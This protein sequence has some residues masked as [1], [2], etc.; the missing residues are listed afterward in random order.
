MKTNPKH[1]FALM[2]FCL[3][4]SVGISQTMVNAT[5]IMRNISNKTMWDGHVMNVFG[6][7]P[8]IGTVP[9]PGPTIY[10]NEGDTLNIFTL[11]ISQGSGHTIHP[12]G[13]DVPQNMD[14]VHETSFE[15]THMMDTNLIWVATHAG[16][17]LYHC[18]MASV[19][20]VQMGMYGSIVVR[21]AGGA[22]TAYTGGPA[23][24]QEKLWLMSEM[25]SYWH[26]SLPGSAHWMNYFQVPP[27]HPDYFLVNG[28]S[29]FQL[30]DTS[31]AAIRAQV[32]EKVYVRLSNIGYNMDEVEFPADMNA[33]ILSADGRP[34]PPLQRNKINVC[35]GER[36]GVML[37]PS[38]ELSYF[39][40]IRYLDM[41][42]ML[43]LGS[44]SVPIIISG[45]LANE[46]AITNE[47]AVECWP[48][49]AKDQINVRFPDG[50]FGKAQFMLLSTEGKLI[51][52][53]EANILKGK[54]YSFDLSGIASGL[55][56]L[57]VNAKGKQSSLKIAVE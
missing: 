41:N 13:M 20:H 39:A 6:F 29:N 44:N 56:L 14:G 16:T 36:Y 12:H 35:P 57:Q 1:I 52:K 5:L 22:K 34:V 45:T 40:T 24:N 33:T 31:V 32:N 4:A 19:L 48:N 17:Y 27:Y 18:H 28:M 49:P 8:S 23:F 11:N 10:C 43:P 51:R 3:I 30:E 55:Y 42:T 54:D 2:A 25:D 50:E 9:V 53:S 26:D 38:Q 46:A 37:T 47:L 7:G 15:I 21:A